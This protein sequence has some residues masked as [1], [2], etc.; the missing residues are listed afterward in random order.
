MNDEQRLSE[1]LAGD[2]APEDAT[3]LRKQIASDPELAELWAMMRDLPAHL[4]DLPEE[5][6]PPELDT[7]VIEAITP[8]PRPV[9]QRWRP[10]AAALATAALAA[11]TLFWAWPQPPEFVIVD[12][13]QRVTGDVTVWA[14]DTQVQVDGDVWI[15][16]EPAEG[17][18]RRPWTDTESPMDRTHLITGLAGAAVTVAVI[19]GSALVIPGSTS[20]AAVLVKTGETHTSEGA[21]VKRVEVPAQPVRPAAAVSMDKEV[22]AYVDSIE[23]RLE[24]LDLEN[25]FLKG[26]LQTYEGTTQAWPEDVAPSL[27]PDG[28]QT[29]LEA[30]AAQLEGFDLSDL[31]CSE[32]PCI[33]QFTGLGDPA[34]VHQISEAMQGHLADQFDD[35]DFD[36]MASIAIKQHEEDGP[37]GVSMQVVAL[38]N[39]EEADPGMQQRLQ[40]R[41]Q[42]L[43]ESHD[44]E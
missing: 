32:Y 26:Q 9:P 6:V 16:V 5:P 42:D 3:A 2:L 21:Q 41:M 20:E 34:D 7:A 4:N 8:E 11:A 14:A 44:P 23:A 40:R 27:T 33:G 15:L 38:D 36:V 19:Q 28:F 43:M 30:V 1:L 12:G 37:A 17:S 24:A 22:V 18:V 39:A 31:D 25:A 10:G 29:A 13:G 35:E